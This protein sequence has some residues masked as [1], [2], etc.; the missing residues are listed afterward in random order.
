MVAF[1]AIFT[2]PLSAMPSELKKQVT[3]WIDTYVLAQDV[4]PDEYWESLK[5]LGA[6]I[7]KG[8]AEALANL[9]SYTKEEELKKRTSIK[10][11]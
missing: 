10:Q 5:K 2:L 7:D 6:R 8:T 11:I 9:D 3:E 1:A 4:N